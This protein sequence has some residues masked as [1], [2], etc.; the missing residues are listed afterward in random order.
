MA[1]Q[2]RRALSARKLSLDE[3]A[4]GNWVIRSTGAKQ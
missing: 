1:A 4:P 2:L 3:T